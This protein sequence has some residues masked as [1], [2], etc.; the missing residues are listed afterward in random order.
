MEL[1]G[2]EDPWLLALVKA[3][4]KFIM[5]TIAGTV[6]LSFVGL[7]PSTASRTKMSLKDQYQINNHGFPFH[8]LLHHHPI[9]PLDQEKP[10]NPLQDLILLVKRKE[11]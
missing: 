10:G 2:G 6:S 3:L 7:F 8:A 4:L 11:G 5:L 9:H 1:G